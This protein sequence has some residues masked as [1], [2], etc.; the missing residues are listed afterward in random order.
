MWAWAASNDNRKGGDSVAVACMQLVPRTA[1]P[2]RD[3]GINGQRYDRL[4]QAVA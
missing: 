1:A 3:D 2:R 4:T